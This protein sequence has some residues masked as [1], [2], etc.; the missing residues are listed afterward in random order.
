[1]KRLIR[2]YTFIEKYIMKGAWIIF[3]ETC[4]K[5]FIIKSWTKTHASS[6]DYEIAFNAFRLIY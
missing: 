6:I 3:L 4:L 5:N 2:N 1:M